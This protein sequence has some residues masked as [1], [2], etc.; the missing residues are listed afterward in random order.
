MTLQQ[1]L[2]TLGLS[3]S[4]SQQ[5]LTAAYSRLYGRFLHV[6]QQG[7]LPEKR[8]QAL[9]NLASLQEA[10]RVLTGN[11]PPSR[12]DPSFLQ[13]GAAQPLPRVSLTGSATPAG[14]AGTAKAAHFN[15]SPAGPSRPAVNNRPPAPYKPASRPG[16]IPVTA[17][18]PSPASRPTQPSTP[19]SRPRTPG[20]AEDLVTLVILGTMLLGAVFVLIVMIS[21]L[22]SKEPSKPPAAEVTHVRPADQQVQRLQPI[23]VFTAQPERPSEPPS[24]GY[25][26]IRTD[27]SVGVVHGSRTVCQ[28]LRRR[29]PRQVRPAPTDCL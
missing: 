28:S 7:Q 1:A 20:F 9:K 13:T 24:D 14:K 26:I 11:P 27:T 5:E 15:P 16:P 25:L 3:G 22:T 19:N 10:Y 2:S 6:A 29:K 4:H 18:S 12:I 17:C 8:E 23:A 21:C